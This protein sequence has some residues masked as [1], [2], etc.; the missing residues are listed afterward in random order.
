MDLDI[1]CFRLRP[2]VFEGKKSQEYTKI[3]SSEKPSRIYRMRTTLAIYYVPAWLTACSCWGIT[4]QL[5]EN[6]QRA[7]EVPFFLSLSMETE[8]NSFGPNWIWK[9][10]QILNDLVSHVLYNRGT[11]PPMTH[12]SHRP[13]IISTCLLSNNKQKKKEKRRKDME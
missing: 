7:K 5:V 6:F 9:S 8:I 3:K 13:S 4:W 1:I 2:D 11:A 10:L 12:S